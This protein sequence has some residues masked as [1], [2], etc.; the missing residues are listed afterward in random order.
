MDMSNTKYITTA[1][2]NL[3]ARLYGDRYEFALNAAVRDGVITGYDERS[4]SSWAKRPC[5]MSDASL[6]I[7][8]LQSREA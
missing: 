3:I 5:W 7:D 2:A 1:Q 6:V 8:W 4:I